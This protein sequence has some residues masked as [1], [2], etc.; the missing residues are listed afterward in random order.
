MCSCSVRKLIEA[1]L[2][3][4]KGGC[5]GVNALAH[6]K[7]EYGQNVPYSHE[8]QSSSWGEK[9]QKGGRPLGN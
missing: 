9:G 4:E 8:I 2:K 5:E 1:H 7:T 3:E 6:S